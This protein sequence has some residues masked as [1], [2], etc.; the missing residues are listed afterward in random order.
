MQ[1]G[2]GRAADLVFRS[3]EARIQSGAL[4]EGQALPSER[5]LMEEFG[6]SRTVVREA[7]RSLSDR[8]L[9]ESRPRHRPV[10]RKPGFDTAFDTVSSVV[11]HLLG[12]SGGVKN[13]FDTRIMIEAALVREAAQSATKDDIAAMQAALDANGEATENSALFYETDMAFH[14]VLY[15]VPRNPVLPAI[16]K[17][18]T[19]WLSPH[20]MQ[21]D[22][23]PHRHH[24]N[25]LAHKA[26]FDTILLRDPDAAEA[27]LRDHL[28]SAWTQVSRTFEDT[29]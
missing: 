17:A 14:A 1:N 11:T 22:N 15:D 23:P 7:I 3:I 8:G 24:A 12:Q 6:A 18:Y 5:D 28:R 2:L 16:H 26:I 4:S 20:W 25:Y 21:M 10:V 13:L 19:A 27:A 9:V 29:E